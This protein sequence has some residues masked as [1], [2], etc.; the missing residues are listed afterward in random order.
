[1]T[2]FDVQELF[3]SLLSVVMTL[4]GSTEHT[5]PENGFISVPVF[6]GVTGIVTVTVPPGGMTTLVPAVQPKS[7][8]TIEQFTVPVVP[9]EPT[10]GEP[11][12]A[13]D[14]GS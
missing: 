3:P 4:F 1:V 6:V 13:P 12:V 14:V 9:V 5:P 2:E 7:V 10:V 11:Y 8:P